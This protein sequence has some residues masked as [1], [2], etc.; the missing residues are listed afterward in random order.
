MQR[1]RSAPRALIALV[2]DRRHRRRPPAAAPPRRR[3]PPPRIAAAAATTAADRDR[4]SSPS[5]RSRIAAGPGP[6]GG[7]GR[8]LVHRHRQ[9]RQARA[10]RR[11]AGVRDRLQRR[12]EGR[13][14]VGRDLRQL[15]RRRARSRPQIAAGNPPDIIGPVGV[16]GLN[17]FRDN[18]LDLAPLI[19]SAELRHD[20][21]R[22]G[23]GRLL[24]DRRGRRARS[25]S[26]SPPIRRSSTTTRSCSTRPSCRIRRP[27]SATCT[28]ASRG[29]W[30]PSAQLGMKL[31]VDKNGNDATSADF[32]PANI[33]QWGFD[34]QWADDRRRQPR[35]TL[36]GAGSVGRRRRQDRPDHRTS[37]KAGLK[38]FN[39]GV[40]K[41]HFI[42]NA[43]QIQ[44]DLL[45]QGQRVPVGQPGHGRDPQLVHVL[46]QPGRAGQASFTLGLRGRPGLQ[47]R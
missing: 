14:P 43:T 45:A 34:M 36:F 7:D 32:D 9:R 15:G 26:R 25:A 41:D 24:Q 8:P 16:E 18:L 23:A 35:P 4:R 46:H 40:W 10:D 33:V 22:P 28:K 30:T 21:V 3:V 13:L 6:N 42:P 20:Q 2:G 17:I 39:D 19:E 11:R 31:T 38:W 29:T 1:S 47:R 5:R 27:R 37:S 12:P 44:S